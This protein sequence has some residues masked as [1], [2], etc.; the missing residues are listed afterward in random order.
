MLGCNGINCITY[1]QP[2]HFSNIKVTGMGR[3][4]RSNIVKNY[5]FLF[6]PSV[7]LWVQACSAAAVD[8]VS[9]EHDAKELWLYPLYLFCQIYKWAVVLPYSGYT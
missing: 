1:L 4:L 6:Q 2:G 7:G 8:F 5:K 9:L 3:I